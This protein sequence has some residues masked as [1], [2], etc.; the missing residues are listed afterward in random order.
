MGRHAGLRVVIATADASDFETVRGLGAQEVIDGPEARRHPSVGCFKAG[1]GGPYEAWR[2]GTVL[3][4]QRHTTAHLAR[5]AAVLPLADTR[6][7]HE[8]L[9]GSRSRPRGKIVLSVAE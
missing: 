1:P 6:V 5:I 9:E 4:G 3:S 2:A 8:M 7:A